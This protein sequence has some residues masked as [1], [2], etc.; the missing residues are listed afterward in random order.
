MNPSIRKLM[1][2]VMIGMAAALIDF[3]IFYVLR[4]WRCCWPIQAESVR[5]LQFL[6][7]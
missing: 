5:G 1:L 7:S 6:S 4:R 2:Y 3:L